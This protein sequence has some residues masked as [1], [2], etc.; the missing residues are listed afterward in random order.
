MKSSG[1]PHERPG[2][3]C[4]CPKMVRAARS[5]RKRPRDDDKAE[6]LYRVALERIRKYRPVRNERGKLVLPYYKL[7]R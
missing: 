6:A 5:V 4:C 1:R 3:M 7:S 2:P